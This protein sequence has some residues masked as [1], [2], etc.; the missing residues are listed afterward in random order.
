M[1]GKNKEEVRLKGLTV[2]E[3]RCELLGMMR[4]YGGG[5]VRVTLDQGDHWFTISVK[6]KDAEGEED[7][8]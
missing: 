2:E 8:P 6:M 4:S 7:E 5:E 1:D 3:V